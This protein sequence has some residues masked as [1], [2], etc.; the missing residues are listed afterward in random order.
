MFGL[1]FNS[2]KKEA[3]ARVLVH[4]KWEV[5]S[6]AENE[7][8]ESG[9]FEGYIF[10]FH[11]NERVE[12]IK[13]MDNVRGTWSTGS[14]FEN[15]DL[16]LNFGSVSPLNELNENWQVIQSSPQQLRLAHASG[17][18]GGTDQLLFGKVGF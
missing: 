4:G 10:A 2:C 9:Q 12:A 5:V 18:N 8:D 17:G 1:I 13:G 16:Y 15:D 7:V 14:D 11:R 3:A 6:F